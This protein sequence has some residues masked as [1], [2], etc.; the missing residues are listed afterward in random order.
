MKMEF[1]LPCDCGRRVSVSAVQAGTT[2]TCDCGQAMSVPRLGELRKLAG[3]EPTAFEPTFIQDIQQ[4]V[5]SN[6]PFASPLSAPHTTSPSTERS[7][8]RLLWI[9]GRA[10]R[11]EFWALILLGYFT[12]V[13]ISGFA[14][15]GRELWILSLILGIA[16]VWIM[17]TAQ[18][19]R[20]HDH[21][22]SGLWW[23]ISFIPIIGPI[24]QFIELGFL[25]GT[26]GENEYGPDPVRRKTY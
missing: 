10:S 23:F 12:I 20:W 1:E 17:I 14:R 18:I 3:L 2:V 13:T 8:A 26:V 6:N 24:W 7:Y 22:K 21:N 15:A 5:D 19:R 16:A 11:S 9:E 25:E 4:A